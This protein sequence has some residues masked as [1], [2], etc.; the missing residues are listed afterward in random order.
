[1]NQPV[2]Q[3]TC[4]WRTRNTTRRGNGASLLNAFGRQA[5]IQL[6]IKKICEVLNLFASNTSTG[7]GSRL[8]CYANKDELFMDGAGI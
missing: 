8:I 2:L 5:V 1:M 3:Q 7:A 4:T 6:A